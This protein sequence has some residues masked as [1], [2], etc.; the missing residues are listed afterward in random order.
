MDENENENENENEMIAEEF[1]S[2]S[3]EA[4]LRLLSLSP[5]ILLVIPEP[6]MRKKNALVSLATARAM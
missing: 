1:S 2:A 3:P 4:F 5:A 6:L